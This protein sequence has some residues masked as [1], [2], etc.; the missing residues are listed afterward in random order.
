M[1]IHLWGVTQSR[2]SAEWESFLAANLSSLRC[3][4]GP[5]C[6]S[7]TGR[8]AHG[9]LLLRETTLECPQSNRFRS[10][11][12]W[13]RRDALAR[14]AATMVLGPCL[15]QNEKIRVSGRLLAC[16]GHYDVGLF[17]QGSTPPDLASQ[18]IWD[19]NRQK[20]R[21]VPGIISNSPLILSHQW[22]IATTFLRHWTWLHASSPY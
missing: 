15:C 4:C 6:S 7:S 18:L 20:P 5:T 19:L 8:E 14:W 17:R 9:W 12:S 13:R 2:H 21:K 22:S 11:T 1:R 16:L 10:S 3:R